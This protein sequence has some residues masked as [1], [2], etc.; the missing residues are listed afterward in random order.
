MVFKEKIGEECQVAQGVMV[1]AIKPGN[2]SLIPETHMVE[3]TSFSKL[4][5]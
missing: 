3:K 1:L 2:L 5:S 4:S